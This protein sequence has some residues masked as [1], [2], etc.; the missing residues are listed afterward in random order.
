MTD[1]SYV[2]LIFAVFFAG[3]AMLLL[4]S[5][6]YL[7]TG[8]ETRRERIL[9]FLKPGALKVY[10]QQFFPS[11]DISKDT[12]A[13]LDARFKKHFG[14]YYGKRHYVL[15]MIILAV[16]AGIGGW[17]TAISVQVSQGVASAKS[18]FPAVA[19]SALLGAFVWVLADQLTRRQTRDLKPSDLY[20]GVFRFLIA[21]P[22]GFGLQPFVAKE[23][24][25][26]L[27][28]LLGAF[29]TDTLFK[30]A[31]RLAGKT[32]AL[33]EEVESG[34]TELEE[35]QNIGKSNAERFRDEGVATIAELAW[36]DPIDLSIRTNFEFNYVVDCMSQALLW[37]Y[38][39][40]DNK[41]KVLYQFSLRGAQEVRTTVNALN[42]N[43]TQE[44]DAAAQA[45][46]GAATALNMEQ[47]ALYH[48]LLEVSKD[49]YTE[50][51]TEIWH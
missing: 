32:L 21:V 29:P 5:I 38:F 45:L 28:F 43:S 24:G 13:Q 47:G 14:A 22:F 4:P 11:V 46:A 42:S 39:S 37:I 12:D 35:L 18:A 9:T 33:G 25:I 3:W 41:F 8:W 51:L 16:V 50:F 26:P 27:A 6:V 17:G 48:T 30:I 7:F 31:R 15:P 23:L 49:P 40:V 19:I 1:R 10:Y 34:K 36:A 20:Y 44:R 2:H